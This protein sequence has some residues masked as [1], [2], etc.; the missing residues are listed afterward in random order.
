LILVLITSGCG[1][2]PNPAAE[3]DFRYGLA[4]RRSGDQ[5]W[6]FNSSGF[7]ACNAPV[8]FLPVINP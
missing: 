1:N 7:L 5:G 6:V 2:I 3:G 8:K 4:F